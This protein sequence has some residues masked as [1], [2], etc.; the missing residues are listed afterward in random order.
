MQ[1][2]TSQI[3]ASAGTAGGYLVVALL[4]LSGALLSALSISGTWF[5]VGACMLSAWLSG[6]EFPGWITV[7]LFVAVA[8]AIEIAEAFAGAL[9]IQKRGGSRGAGLAALGGGLLGLF[10]GAWIPIPLVGPLLGLFAGSF[11]AAYAVEKRRLGCETKAAH[12][13]RGAVLARLAILLLKLG[14]TLAMIAV[15]LAGVLLA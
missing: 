8:A 15:L 7:V 9:G 4:C 13:A 11:W 3:L 5:V 6:P 12:I 10:V 14:V 2:D 1:I